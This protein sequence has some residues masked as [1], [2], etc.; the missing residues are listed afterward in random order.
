MTLLEPH[1]LPFLLALIALVLISFAQILGLGDLF[2]AGDVDIDVDLDI[3][4][5]G[6]SE[7]DV[8]PEALTASGWVAGAFSLLGLGKVPFLIW[9]MVLLFVFAAIG[10]AGQQFMIALIGAPLS[11]ALAAVLAGLAALPVNGVI[12]R[13]L[14]KLLPQDE[15]SA[16]P[17][18]SLVRRDAEIQ[19]GI[20]KTGSPARS[21]VLDIHGHP[22]FVM[23]E[24]HD[25]EAAL[26]EGETVLLVRREGE[27]F[28]AVRYESPMLQV[29]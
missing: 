3:E 27:T 6:E 24:P 2:D 14:A 12:T 15:T 21:K 28:Y 23:V 11:A 19:I 16:V 4:A 18:D 10:V 17:L 1:N 8:D 7:F 9:L 25:P 29:T 5:A 26:S 20:A 22:H 13:P